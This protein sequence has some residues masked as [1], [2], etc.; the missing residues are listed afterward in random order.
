MKKI[1]VPVVESLLALCLC[2]FPALAQEGNPGPGGRPQ[3]QGVLPVPG[4]KEQIPNLSDQQ[5]EQMRKLALAFSGKTLP[6][7]NELG[8]KEARLRSLMT[9]LEPDRPA[10]DKV[11]DDIGNLTKELLKARVANDLKV[12][13]V[14]TPEQR[15]MRDALPGPGM[16]PPRDMDP[17]L[18]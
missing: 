5:K 15:L 10:I 11:V 13:E 12:N 3:H 16:P 2:A 6:L 7:R 14:L 4:G 8:E 1:H 17:G 9:A 18:H